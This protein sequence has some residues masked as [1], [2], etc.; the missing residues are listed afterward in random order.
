LLPVTAVQVRL[1]LHLLAATIWVGGM[2]TLAGLLPT[3]RALGEDAPQKVARAFNRIA[4]PAFGIL[5]LTGIW[6]LL[7]VD[8][9]D[10]STEYQVTLFV[11]LIVVA[12]SGVSAALHTR[13]TSR[14]GLAVGGAL[15]AA[16][17]LA[18]VFLGIQLHG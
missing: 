15:S 10:R 1:F 3:V 6:N 17:A 18:A 7:E 11:K 2:F 16:S 13:A 5:V 9:A 8:V 12:I 4:W 14:A